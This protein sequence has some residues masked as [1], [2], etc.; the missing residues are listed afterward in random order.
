MNSVSFYALLVF[1]DSALSGAAVAVIVVV[2]VAVVVVVV[3]VGANGRLFPAHGPS[4]TRREKAR[5]ASRRLR[6]HV[7][8]PFLFPSRRPPATVGVVFFVVCFSFSFLGVVFRTGWDSLV[9]VVCFFVGSSL[10]FSP[11]SFSAGVVMKF[12]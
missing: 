7:S 9:S 12:F 3:R 1:I 2:A 10:R 4:A 11:N 6:S 8:C 5:A